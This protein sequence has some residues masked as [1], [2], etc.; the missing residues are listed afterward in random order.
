MGIKSDDT[1]FSGAHDL[2]CCMTVLNIYV[3][4]VHFA[5]AL[6]P[7]TPQTVIPSLVASLHD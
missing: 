3:P 6:A 5:V 7:R 1:A 2:L 4:V